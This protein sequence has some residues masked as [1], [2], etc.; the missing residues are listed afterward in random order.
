MYTFDHY[1]FWSFEHLGRSPNLF[2]KLVAM[3]DR[4]PPNLVV[5]KVF[6]YS[7]LCYV[8]FLNTAKLHD[9]DTSLVTIHVDLPRILLSFL[10]REKL[11]TVHKD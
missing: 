7:L 10:Y 6:Y 11:Q 1:Q 4:A 2:C 9:V 5:L 8:I 3:I